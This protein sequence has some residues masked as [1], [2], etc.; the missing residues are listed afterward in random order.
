MLNRAA[1]VHTLNADEHRLLGDLHLKA[2]RRIV[3]NAVFLDEVDDPGAD[4]ECAAHCAMLREKP[5]VLFLGR[6]HYKKG[7][8]VLIDAFAKIAAQH[9][10]MQL[11]IVGPDGGERGKT[12]QRAAELGLADRVHLAGPLY[13]AAKFAAYRRANCFCLPSRQEG[14]SLSITEALASRTPVVISEG[15]H[16]PEVEQFGAGE[17]APLDPDAF[18]EALHRVLAATPERRQMM[19]NAGRALVQRHFTWERVAQMTLA[20]YDSIAPAVHS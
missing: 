4:T 15:C 12:L 1:F 2:P 7:L 16:F 20:A 9:P 19:G 3:P 14:F 6:L 11:L 17:V 18:A 8:D 10:H 13:G 5:Y